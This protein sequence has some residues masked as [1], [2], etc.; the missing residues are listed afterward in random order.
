MRSGLIAQHN[1]RQGNR[2]SDP[3]QEKCPTNRAALIPIK[4]VSK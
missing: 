1:Q 3:Y 4:F 2:R